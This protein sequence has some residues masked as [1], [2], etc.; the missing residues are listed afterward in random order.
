MLSFTSGSSQTGSIRVFDF[1]A[2]GS[3][4]KTVNYIVLELNFYEGL[5]AVK[6]ICEILDFV[7]YS[8][9]SITTFC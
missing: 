1:Q 4:I 2:Y 9:D 3:K 8:A 5:I 7:D 6:H